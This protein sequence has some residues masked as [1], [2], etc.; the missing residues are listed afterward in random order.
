MATSNEQRLAELRRLQKAGGGKLD[1]RAV[2]DA[3][4]AA[5]NPLHGDFTWD[6]TEAAEKWRLE[7]AREI[8]RVT[9]VWEPRTERNIRAFVS[10]PAD[11][12][13]GGGYRYVP[14][15]VKTVNG[16]EQMLAAAIAELRQVQ[17]KY[18]DVE[19]LAGV[20]AEIE[21]AAKT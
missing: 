11:R 2:V 7:Q 15:V 1:P 5:D 8:I 14:Q 20:F 9:V 12:E 18:R 19:Q 13:A 4:R 10:L 16:R 3:A 6:D 21:K 17:E